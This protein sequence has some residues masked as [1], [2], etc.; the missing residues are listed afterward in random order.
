MGIAT[1][2]PE[3]R[4]LFAGEPEHLINY[5]FFIA[6]QLRA[7]M[8]ELGFRTVNEMVGRVDKLDGRAAIEHWKARGFDFSA[9]LHRPQVP[10]GIATY[11]C[12][13]QDHAI[14]GG[15][16]PPDH[17]GEPGRGGEAGAG[18]HRAAR[19]ATRTAQ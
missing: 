1:Q 14:E 6:D 4:K 19:S 11:C 17:R 3:L 5:F 15:A 16:G 18:P 13:A 10:E 8:A 2:D 7:I 9:L 12:E